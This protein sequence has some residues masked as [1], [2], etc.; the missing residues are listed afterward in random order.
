MTGGPLL[1]VTINPGGTI[2]TAQIQMLNSLDLA[3]VTNNF[4]ALTNLINLTISGVTMNFPALVDFDDGNVSISGG[5]MVT[6][7][8]LQNYTKLSCDGA[9]WTVTGAGSVFSLP[10]LTN[11]SG[12]TCSFPTIQAEAGGEILASN[13]VSVQVA[14]LTFQA[15]GAGSLINLSAL[16]NCAGQDGYL[17]NFE[18]SS[19]GTVLIPKMTGGPLVGVTINSGGTMPTS[20]ILALN[21]LD[22]PGVTNNFNAL[23][24]LVNLTVSAVTMN[25]P[26]LTNFNDGNVTVSGGAVVTMPAL[27][28]YTKLSCEGDNWTVTGA[29][30][31]LNL[32]ALTNIN[33]VT[34]S[35]PVI[36]AEA[37][38]AIIA[39]NLANVQLGPLAFQ[40]DGANSLI[41]L[42][43]LTNG[44]GQD[45]YQLTFEASSGGTLQL[46]K[47]ASG[48]LVG[49]TFNAG[50]AMAPT[51]LTNLTLS[52]ITL[53]TGSVTLPV[54]RDMDASSLNVS[55]GAVL[56][57]PEVGSYAAGA[58]VNAV[59]E[60]NGTGSQIIL[61]GL[62]NLTGDATANYTMEMEA[63]AGGL[64]T[65]S[66]LQAIDNGNVTI[67]SDGT[68]S[69]INLTSLSGF[70]L[71]N[72]LGS[73][74]AQN[75]GTILLNTQAFLLANVA[76][77][78]PAGNPVLPPTLIASS[79]LTLYGQAWH[80]Y[81]VEERNT[82][83]PNSPFTFL[84]RVPLTNSFEAI[85]PAP[86]PN[87][88]YLVTEFV[89]NPPI[90]DVLSPA[91]QV[92]LIL[93][94]ATGKT[95]QIQTATNLNHPI[96]WTNISSVV[97]TNS[98]FI[99]PPVA[100]SQPL[101]YYRAKQL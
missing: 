52:S 61:A 4:N 28:D 53:P 70:V 78:I 66:N 33:G 22:L 12:E 35:F 77:N 37:G 84:A 1:G 69:T 50:G 41:N 62:T 94:A 25:F 5:A 100:P 14:P 59:W 81:L 30:S 99:F 10:A 2:P 54:L 63:L 40:A 27:Q 101:L 89:A 56:S 92:Q 8:A 44:A 96:T 76:I 9:N 55:G 24:T 86:P 16:S 91:G 93:Y 85:A 38:G 82:L 46:P 71:L 3:G 18:A 47:L 95:N 73:V 64:L 13:V 65:V 29:N 39:T 32:P 97:M 7:P 88:A 74:T 48:Q 20:Q 57:L 80:S 98:F 90:L 87:T 15:D 51:N 67:L 26:A 43:G 21:T 45:N 23:N 83:I 49:F 58:S 72:G 42:S 34:C 60:A 79:A 68:G 11:I 75:G 17:V 6:M 31:V 19:G 36:Q